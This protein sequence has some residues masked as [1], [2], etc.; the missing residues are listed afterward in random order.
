MSST[1]KWL[2]IKQVQEVNATKM[3]SKSGK[4]AFFFVF[5]A[6]FFNIENKKHWF[7]TCF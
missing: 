5:P 4:N 7:L 6:F 3:M 1:E 2:D